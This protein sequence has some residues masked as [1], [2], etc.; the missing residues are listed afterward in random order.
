MKIEELTKIPLSKY[1]LVLAEGEATGHRHRIEC[2]QDAA[3]LYELPAGNDNAKLLVVHRE[4]ALSHEEHRTIRLVP[5]MYRIGIKRHQW[6]ETED[7][8]WRPVAD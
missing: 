7:A 1:G 2:E 6:D 4:V 3:D 5:G 8:G